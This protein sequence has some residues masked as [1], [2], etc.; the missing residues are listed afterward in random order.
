M[1]RY[2][3]IFLVLSLVAVSSALCNDNID[4]LPHLS[5]FPA[6]K[7]FPLFTADGLAHQ[8]SLSRVTE[9]REWIGAVGG[10]VPMLQLNLSNAAM[11]AGVAV[12]IFNRLIKTPGHLTVYTIDYKVDFPID[13]RF[14]EWAFR[15]GLG[16]ISCHFADDALEMFDKHS[17]Q[18]VND[19]FTIAAARDIEAIGGY[20]YA[21]FNYSYGTQPIQY[22]PWL[23]QCG[24]TFG[25]IPVH[26]EVTLYGAI[27]IKVKQE[28]GWGSIQSYQLGCRVLPRSHASLRLAYTFRTGFDDRGQFYLTKSSI[29]L[30]SAFLDF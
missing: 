14:G 4:S 10:S 27:D 19:Y 13:F 17:I 1:I 11:Q 22:R 23:L 24:T 5:F 9:N 29:N 26:E 12:T 18:H 6:K 15:T 25:N 7:I 16:H 21:G 2:F 3:K 28:V 30:I 8:L 20:V